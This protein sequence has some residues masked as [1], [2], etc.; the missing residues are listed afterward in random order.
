VSF[1]DLEARA[2][3]AVMRRLA[4][5]RAL[6]VG[7]VEDFA[8]IFDIGSLETDTGATAS[9]PLATALDS[10]VDGFEAHSTQVKVTK[11]GTTTTYT[12]RDLRP[13]GAGFT[14]MV[15]ESA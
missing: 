8:V 3:A 6:R 2:N 15:L 5:A 13:D 12:V 9:S 1:A 10:D 11:N 14:V 7:R 4:N